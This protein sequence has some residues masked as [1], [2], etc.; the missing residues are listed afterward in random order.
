MTTKKRMM[1]M[2]MM[3]MRKMTL[4][5]MKQKESHFDSRWKGTLHCA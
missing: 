3:M 2:V 4:M 1:T 5:R